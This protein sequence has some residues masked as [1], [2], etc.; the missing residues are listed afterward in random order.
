VKKTF[1][2]IAV[3]FIWTWKILRTGIMVAGNL[4]L[5]FSLVLLVAMFVFH[6]KIKVPDGAALVLAPE[7]NIVEQ[8]S[9]IDPIARIINNLIGVPEH[10]ETPLQDILDA[11]NSAAVDDRI[12]MLVVSPSRLGRVGLNQLRDIGRAIEQFKE[13]GKIVIA[14]DDSFNQTQ[15]YLASFADEIYLNPMGRV[16][17]HGFGVFRLYF[18]EL[19]DKLHVQF[20]VFRVGTF[21]SALEPFLR[22][23][24]SAAAKEANHQWLSR[25]WTTYC[26]DIGKQR[27]LTVPIINTYINSVDVLLEKTKGDSAVMALNAGLIDGLKTRRQL[28]DYLKSVVGENGSGSEF[29]HISLYDYLNTITPSYSTRP[30]K[31]PAV[32]I[33]VAQG[34]IVGGQG[35]VGQIGADKLIRRLQ[36]ARQDKTIKAVVLRIDSGGGSAFASELIRQEL[37]RTRQS[38]KPVVISMGSMA[39]SGA[40]WLSAD[41]DAILASPVT[42]TG[43]IGIF[44]AL[45]TFEET[46]AKIGVHNDGIGT[47]SMAGAISPARRLPPNVSKTLQLGV[48]HGYRQFIN[49]VAKGRNM[50]PAKVEEIAEGRVWDGK[51]AMEIGLVDA[52]GSLADAVFRAAELAGLDTTTGIYIER[53]SSFLQN[54]RQIGNKTFTQLL[55]TQPL[56]TAW[57]TFPAQIRSQLDFLYQP[58]PAN[59]Y[60]HCLLSSGVIDF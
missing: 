11:V 35:T 27:G 45:P 15:Y 49:I 24:M 2:I 37:I 33:I 59:I 6:P 34:N 57:T 53:P 58:D 12:R 28:E 31:T 14:A 48:E 29:K 51:T 26:R 39:A 52:E 30:E 22:D 40:Y 42:L 1:T 32:G 25:L 7:G 8:R 43:S 17:L 46:L 5:L 36:A 10:K 16:D 41:A 19:I 3:F 60:A 21:K 54:L 4:I 18:K 47:T 56:L 50:P 9:A 23:N 55:K 20:H 38:G 13:S 44:G